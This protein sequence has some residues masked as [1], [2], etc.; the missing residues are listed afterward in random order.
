VVHRRQCE[1]G[2]G[3]F[4]KYIWTYLDDARRGLERSVVG[5]RGREMGLVDAELFPSATMKVLCTGICI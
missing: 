5:G 4:R 1:L 2:V 3:V